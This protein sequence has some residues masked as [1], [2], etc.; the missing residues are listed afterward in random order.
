MLEHYF[1]LD[2]KKFGTMCGLIVAVAIIVTVIYWAVFGFGRWKK[3]LNQASSLMMAAT[4]V[5]T[6]ATAPA[7]QTMLIAQP[8]PA[9]SLPAGT[10]QYLCP[11]HGAV[12]LPNLDSRGNACC[13]I[14]GQAMTFNST[15]SGNLTLAAAGAG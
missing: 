10:G 14:C 12:G 6:A 11:Q 5:P 4:N 7:G 9:R 8:A 15:S 1:G 3:E 2:Q 13:P